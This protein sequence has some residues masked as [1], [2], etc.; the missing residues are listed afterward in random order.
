LDTAK[1]QS[2]IDSPS[3]GT[4]VI[5]HTPKGVWMAKAIAQRWALCFKPILKDNKNQ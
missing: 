2:R 1:N 4:T 3:F 5:G